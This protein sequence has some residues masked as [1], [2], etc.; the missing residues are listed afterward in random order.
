MNMRYLR[1]LDGNRNGKKS[2]VIAEVYFNGYI[3]FVWLT[4]AMAAVFIIFPPG[5]TCFLNDNI[6]AK[7][8]R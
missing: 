2:R 6:T 7:N 8:V 3:V 5:M 1:I 4:C